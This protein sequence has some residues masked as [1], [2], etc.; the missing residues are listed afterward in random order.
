MPFDRHD[1]HLTQVAGRAPVED[2]VTAN[3][4]SWR[5][6]F[7]PSRESAAQKVPALGYRKVSRLLQRREKGRDLLSHRIVL[8]ASATDV[9]DPRFV[10]EFRCSTE[11]LLQPPETV[12]KHWHH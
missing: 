12:S 5:C 10:R 3:R 9:G 8:R 11:D 6:T 4:I 1:P 7:H 2:R